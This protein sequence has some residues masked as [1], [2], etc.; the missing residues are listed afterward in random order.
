MATNH[1]GLR[2][3]VA[4]GV[5]GLLVAERN[6]EEL[7]EA[8]VTLLTDRLLRESLGRNAVDFVRQN[9]DV[10]GGATALDALYR[11]LLTL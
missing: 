11:K 6:P 2:E 4:D 9:Y 7:A 8:L 10:A 5:S 3:A 1:G